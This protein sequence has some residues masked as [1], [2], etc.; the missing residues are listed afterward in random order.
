MKNTREDFKK[1]RAMFDGD[2]GFM[3]GHQ[4]RKIRRPKREMPEWAASQTS[5]QEILLKAFPKL[6][7][8]DTQRK[9]AGRWARVI[10]LYFRSGFSYRETAG[11]LHEKRETIHT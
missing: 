11:Y 5:I 3:Y 2:D 1:L 8:D 7:T 6:I 10:Q 9:A 4:P